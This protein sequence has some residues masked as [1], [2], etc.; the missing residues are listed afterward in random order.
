MK[1]GIINKAGSILK[2]ARTEQVQPR[3]QEVS[4]QRI[5]NFKRETKNKNTHKGTRT[6][7]SKEYKNINSDKFKSIGQKEVEQMNGTREMSNEER[8]QSRRKKKRVGGDAMR[9]R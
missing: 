5:G 1:F 4:K 2:D 6:K 7:M 8:K 9:H 3:D